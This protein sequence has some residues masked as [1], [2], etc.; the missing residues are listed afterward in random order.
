MTRVSVDLSDR[1]HAEL[2]IACFEDHTTMGAQI[3]A[4]VAEYL[5]RRRHPSTGHP[6]NQAPTVTGYPER[7]ADTAG[8]AD[9]LTVAAY[10]AG[11]VLGD[12]IDTD[13]LPPY[14]QESSV[15]DP[16]GTLDPFEDGPVLGAEAAP[17]DPDQ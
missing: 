6:S 10:Q 4:L 7:P 15:A 1:T 12:I 14:P 17:L 13:P 5:S 2:R 3:R 11:P 16:V 9:D 8:A